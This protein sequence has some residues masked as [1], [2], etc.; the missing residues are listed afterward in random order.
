MKKKT[1]FG[2]TLL[3]KKGP[4]AVEHKMTSNMD[5]PMKPPTMKKGKKKKSA[6]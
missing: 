3:K 1:A 2:K 6:Y 5:K 4:A